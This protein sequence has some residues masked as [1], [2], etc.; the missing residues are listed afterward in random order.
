M[1]RLGYRASGADL[2]FGRPER[3]HGVAM[4][5]YFWRIT[6]PATQRVVIALI[7]VQT[8]HTGRWALTGL[9][10]SDGFWRH[11]VVESADARPGGLGARASGPEASFFGTDERVVVDMGED[12]HLDLR[13]DG[14][15]RWPSLRPFGGSSWFQMIPGLN[16]YWHPWLLGGRAS[17][18]V[19]V[20][21]SRWEFVNAQVYGEKNWGRAGF[22]DSWWWGQAQ[23]FAE[24]EACVA[25]A[26]GEVTAGPLRTE[27]TGLVVRLPDGRLLRL[28]NPVTSPVTADI[29]DEHWRLQGR[30]GGWD[31]SVDAHAPLS[32]A[33]VLPVPLVGERRAVPGAIEHLSGRLNVQ[34]NHRGRLVW[35][36]Q[37][38]LAG[39]EHGGLERAGALAASRP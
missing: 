10:A 15:T 27:V 24:A 5:G 37:S 21:D 17:G 8:D 12:A 6:D 13:L 3:A 33:H 9:G 14:L 29:G 18:S 23:A 34:V 28:G 31:I 4:E 26:G 20:G 11:A 36:G 1:R 2:A 16:Q 30:S 19:R 38:A 7:G 39:L 35:E 25:F 22:P 32:A